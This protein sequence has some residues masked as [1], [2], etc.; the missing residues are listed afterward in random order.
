MQTKRCT[1]TEK[2]EGDRM[3]NHLPA[4]PSFHLQSKS[5]QAQRRE[6]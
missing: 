6:M 4:E 3:R 2:Q 5:K 1:L